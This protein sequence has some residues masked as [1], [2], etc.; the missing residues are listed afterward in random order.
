MHG[1]WKVV[2]EA[3][4]T[5]L[6]QRIQSKSKGIKDKHTQKMNEKLRPICDKHKKNVC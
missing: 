3:K 1:G 4:R 5:E 6:S 2:H